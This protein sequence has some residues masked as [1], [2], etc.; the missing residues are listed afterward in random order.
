MIAFSRPALDRVEEKRSSENLE[1][2]F[3]EPLHLQ[4]GIV[5]NGLA[6]RGLVVVVQEDTIPS[7]R[8]PE[9]QD[10]YH[11]PL[12]AVLGLQDGRPIVAVLCSLSRQ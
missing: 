8:Q 1:N 12:Q 2:W 10:I 3:S 9:L 4:P 11:N 5:G 7:R 6:I